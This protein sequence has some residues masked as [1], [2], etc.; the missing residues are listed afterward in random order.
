MS[1]GED[2][3]GT[4]EQPA[5]D[6]IPTTIDEHQPPRAVNHEA[7]KRGEAEI[8]GWDKQS[9]TST[10]TTYVEVVEDRRA[11]PLNEALFHVVAET[12]SLASTDYDFQDNFPVEGR[13]AN[14]G[15]VAPG[16]YRSSFP[17]P[18]N[19]AFVKSLKLKTMVYDLGALLSPVDLYTDVLF[20]TLVQR[21]KIPQGY[22]DFLHKN[23]IQHCVFE[24]K[25]TKK[26]AIPIETMRSILRIV[27]D[28]RNHPL[29]IH[30]NHGKVK[31]RL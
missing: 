23:G 30:C 26:E 22:D 7:A 1:V 14:F 19:Y 11:D 18:E 13:P 9:S 8:D 5:K 3:V 16:V 20:S 2:V 17:Q 28:R 31:N 4:S 25:G 10:A 29:F 21:D 15:V 12:Q 24:M 27:L 6:G